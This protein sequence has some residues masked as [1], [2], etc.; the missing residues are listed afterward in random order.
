[1]KPYQFKFTPEEL[2]RFIALTPEANTPEALAQLLKQIQL[3]G[4]DRAA[5]LQ[6]LLKI[7]NRPPRRAIDSSRS[8]GCLV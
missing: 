3:P 2:Q 4:S 1:M 7:L 6:E 5:G 8:V